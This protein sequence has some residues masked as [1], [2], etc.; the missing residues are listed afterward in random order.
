MG[1][2]RLPLG[3]TYASLCVRID[4]SSSLETRAWEQR[5]K[6]K[7]GFLRAARPVDRGTA[8]PRFSGIEPPQ[9]DTKNV[10]PCTKKSQTKEIIAPNVGLITA[11]NGGTDLATIS[12]KLKSTSATNQEP[13][14]ER[15]T[16][17]RPG[18]MTSTLKQDNQA[19]KSRFLTNERT[20]R[21]GAILP[22]L[23]PSTQFPRPWPFQCPNEPPMES[24]NLRSPGPPAPLPTVFC[25][26][27]VPFGPVHFTNYPLKSEYKEYTLEKILEL[28]PLTCIQSAVR[29]NQKGPWIFST[30]KLFRGKFNY[31]PAY[32]LS[33]ELPMT[34]K[35]MPASTPNL[36]TDH[37]GKLFGIVYITLAGVIDTIILVAGP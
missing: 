9:A 25:P 27:G 23:N 33:M 14:Q 26:P 13:T 29:Y 1:C 32:D 35:P 6:P 7:P 30:P 18:P 37:T 28:N 12:I 8:Y 19:A 21:P 4:Y 16:G 3:T 11:P 10:D 24:V 20:P 31:L 5:S 2:L 17:P 15:G 34:P 36:P 22:P